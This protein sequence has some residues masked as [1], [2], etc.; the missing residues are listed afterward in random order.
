M[1]ERPPPR[2]PD[3]SPETSQAEAQR[4]HEEARVLA[5]AMHRA[6]QASAELLAKSPRKISENVRRGQGHA[7]ATV[8]QSLVG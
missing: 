5:L 2:E 8:A 6:A 4:L 1:S 3:R 7:S